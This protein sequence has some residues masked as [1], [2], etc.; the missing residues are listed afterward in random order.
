MSLHASKA[1][2]LQKLSFSGFGPPRVALTTGV[3][4]PL[5]KPGTRSRPGKHALKKLSTSPVMCEPSTSA[6]VMSITCPY[7]NDAA[8]SY[9]L[10]VCRP[11]IFFSAVISALAAMAAGAASRQFSSLP[12]RGKTP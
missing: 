12:R 7:R 3:M 9:R 5:K 6:S 1:G 4:N 11:R 10:P 8:S 2:T